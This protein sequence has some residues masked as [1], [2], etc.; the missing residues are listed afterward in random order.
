MSDLSDSISIPMH[1]AGEHDL[2][3]ICGVMGVPQIDRVTDDLLETDCPDCADLFNKELQ[4]T[5]AIALDQPEQAVSRL[6]RWIV[7]HP[8][9][10]VDCFSVVGKTLIVVYRRASRA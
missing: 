1:L 5:D 3:P 9:H 6:R 8:E 4:L 2:Y 10:I 7:K